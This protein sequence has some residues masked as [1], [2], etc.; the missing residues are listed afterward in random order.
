MEGK[1]ERG[2][3]TTGSVSGCLGAREIPNCPPLFKTCHTMCK[4]MC[5]SGKGGEMRKEQ[6]GKGKG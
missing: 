1:G 4:F 3:H 5:K 2:E 6:R